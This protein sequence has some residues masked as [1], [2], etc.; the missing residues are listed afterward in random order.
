[1]K[2]HVFAKRKGISTV[3]TTVIIL[4]AS[5]VLGSGVVLYGTS[6]FQTVAQQESVEVQ[7]IQLWVNA[8]DATGDAW[9]AAGVRNNGDQILSVDTISIKGTTVPFANWYF[10]SDQTRVT[11]GNYQSQYVHEGT[12]GAGTIM[13]SSPATDGLCVGADIEIDF[14]GATGEP[15]LCLVQGSGPV[16]LAPG[17]RAII[18]FQ[19]AP[20]TLTTLDAGASTTLNIFA[21]EAG[22]PLSTIIQN[23]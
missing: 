1:M 14:D 20:G 21:G 8:T 7:G 23:P 18:Y 11:T 9:G 17:E 13:N 5:V 15:T 3:L 2:N 10:D 6:I 19:M 12:A 16:G 4:V 22:A